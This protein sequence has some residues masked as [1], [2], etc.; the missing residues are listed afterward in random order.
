M[1]CRFYLGS[2][3]CRHVGLVGAWV[4]AICEAGYHADACFAVSS[5]QVTNS[6]S[7]FSDRTNWNPSRRVDRTDH[8]PMPNS[9]SRKFADKVGISIN[10]RVHL[11]RIAS[12]WSIARPQEQ[13]H[14]GLDEQHWLYKCRSSPV[15]TCSECSALLSS[16]HTSEF[17]STGWARFH[18][19]KSVRR[20]L[21]RWLRN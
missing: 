13:D 2:S 20:T 7:D 9:F 21:M 19:A 3:I 17:L 11:R 15:Q 8:H 12:F 10:D 1:T 16:L 5:C 18:H 14:V 4:Q 6:E